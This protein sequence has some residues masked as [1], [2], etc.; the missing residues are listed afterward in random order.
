MNI[1]Q[2]IKIQILC[3][4][5]VLV[6]SPIFSH[7]NSMSN[8]LRDV[9]HQN[10]MSNYL[11][12]SG[13][14]V[15]H[16]NSVSNCLGLSVTRTQWMTVSGLSVTRT[17]W[18]TVLGMSIIRTQIDCLR[19]ILQSWFWWALVS[20]WSHELHLRNHEGRVI[21]PDGVASP[22]GIVSSH[23]VALPQRILVR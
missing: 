11:T 13:L 19:V 18:M 2:C 21:P 17:Q 15:S 16:Q 5:P 9:S 23:R 7:Q 12:V 14:S 6:A 4:S 22:H 20:F 1:F 8:C 10:S 3:S